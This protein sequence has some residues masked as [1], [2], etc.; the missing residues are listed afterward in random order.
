MHRPTPDLE[1]FG[2]VERAVHRAT[3]TLVGVCAGTGLALYVGPLVYDPVT[4]PDPISRNAPFM[5]FTR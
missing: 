2:P 4:T 1:R 3:A 5:R